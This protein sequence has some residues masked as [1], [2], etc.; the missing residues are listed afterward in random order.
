M[1]SAQPTRTK[2][3]EIATNLET[4]IGTL[5]RKLGVDLTSWKQIVQRHVRA[6]E[7]PL[8]GLGK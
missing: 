2:F 1:S 8:A 4:A 5:G 3:Q 7:L 6:R